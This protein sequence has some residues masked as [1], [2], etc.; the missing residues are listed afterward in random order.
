MDATS[1]LF[2]PENGGYIPQTWQFHHVSE[3][4]EIPIA[5]SSNF[6]PK[7]RVFSPGTKN[8]EWKDTLR[9]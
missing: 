9:N 4:N 2:G 7:K 5:W 3:Q 6:R 8:D 1:M